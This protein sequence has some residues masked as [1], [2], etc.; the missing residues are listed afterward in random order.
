MKQLLGDLCS[1]DN[2]VC[3]KIDDCVLSWQLQQV[4]FVMVY[5]EVRIEC[6]MY[7]RLPANK[8]VEGG[9]TKTLV[10]KLLWNL[11]GRR[12]AGKV[13]VSYFT[14]KLMEVEF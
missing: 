2:M 4:D 9:T 10:L 12:Q 14:Y 11:Y 8:E 7:M 6:G 1:C 13:W 5:M 3:H